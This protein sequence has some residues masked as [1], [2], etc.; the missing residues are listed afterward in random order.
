MKPGGV[1]DAGQPDRNLQGIFIPAGIDRNNG[2]LIFIDAGIDHIIVSCHQA[3]H[4]APLQHPV[5]ESRPGQ[6]HMIVN[7]GQILLSPGIG[8]AAVRL[9]EAADARLI[10]VI[11]GRCP[12]PGHLHHGTQPVDCRV[13]VLACRLGPQ[14]GQPSHI[15]VRPGH[16]AGV[17]MVGQLVHGGGNGTLRHPGHVV[18]HGPEEGLSVADQRRVV[19]VG[20]LLHTRQE[21]AHRLHKSIIIHDG[22]PLISPQ[23]GIRIAVML[24]QDHRL[25]IGLLHGTAEALPEVVIVGLA[26]SQV[27]RHIQ[28]PAVTAIR[29]THP[30]PGNGQYLLL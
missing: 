3:H 12:R 5:V 22:I 2:H 26:V 30:F 24:R 25:R 14:L 1:R 16:K 6:I 28:A 23:P 21:P 18:E 20:M 10:A 15:V 29:R 27:C 11:N 19:A 17:I 7:K 9:C 4:R 13:D 8:A